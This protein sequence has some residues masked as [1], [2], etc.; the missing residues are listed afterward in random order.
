MY[1]SNAREFLAPASPS[2]VLRLM[3][4]VPKVSDCHDEVCITCSD[5]AVEAR[6]IELL[7]DDLARVKVG[8]QTQVISV[9]LIDAQPGEVIL[10]HA[11][12][13]IAKL[14]A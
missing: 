8:G 7:D 9:A 10:V 1:F 13:A 12:E 6:L 14:S 2:E 11:R 3:R 5:L 4:A